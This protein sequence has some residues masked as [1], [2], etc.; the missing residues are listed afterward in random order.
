MRVGLVWASNPHP[1]SPC[2]FGVLMHRFFDVLLHPLEDDVSVPPPP[3][4]PT[5]YFRLS[6]TQASPRL[7]VWATARVSPPVNTLQIQFPAPRQ[8]ALSRLGLLA[9][10]LAMRG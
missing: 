4:T 7:A 5:A 1:G 2:A 3:W 9:G 10:R 8:T 6:F